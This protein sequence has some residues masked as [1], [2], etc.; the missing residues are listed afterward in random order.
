M[1]FRGGEFSTGTKGNFQPELTP[2]CH[3][4]HS[5]SELRLLLFPLRARI[6]QCIYVPVTQPNGLQGNLTPGGKGCGAAPLH[7][8]N[9]PSAQR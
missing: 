7:Q 9:V 4:F 3:F 2:A 1:K 6:G 8:S 5:E